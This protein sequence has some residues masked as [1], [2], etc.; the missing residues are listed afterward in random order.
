MA[1]I[2]WI[3]ASRGISNCSKIRQLLFYYDCRRKGSQKQAMESET[4]SSPTVRSLTGRPSYTT[5]IDIQRAKSV[6]GRLPCYLFSLSKIIW[7]QVGGLFCVFL[8]CP[9]PHWLLQ[10]FPPP[11]HRIHWAQPNVCL[12][13]SALFPSVLGWSL[14]YGSCARHKCMTIAEYH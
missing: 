3:S 9:W 14:S 8:W 2:P 5:A 4:A 7:A 13:V 10:S 6:P 1:G 11:F 12:W